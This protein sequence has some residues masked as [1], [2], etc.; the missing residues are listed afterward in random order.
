MVPEV[1]V[2]QRISCS[3]KLKCFLCVGVKF[4]GVV[5]WVVNKAALATPRL[6]QDFRPVSRTMGGRSKYCSLRQYACMV[7]IVVFFWI[8]L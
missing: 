8:F 3:M 5:K 6:S 1:Q 7:S 2:V 4:L